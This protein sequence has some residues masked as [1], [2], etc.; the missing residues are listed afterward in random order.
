MDRLCR[1]IPQRGSWEGPLSIN[2]KDMLRDA[3]MM[4]SRP[5]LERRS[6]EVERLLVSM[7]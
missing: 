7:N 1:S 2:A 3:L 5:G 4:F 6:S